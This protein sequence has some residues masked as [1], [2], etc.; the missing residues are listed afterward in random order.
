[1]AEPAKKAF[2]CG[3][4]IAH[5]R[6]PKIH[7]YWLK[8]HRIAGTYV[9]RD[10][11]QDDFARFFN[12]FAGDGFVGGNVTIPN[13]E[14]AFA[15][16]ARREE[17]AEA[18]GALNT[19]WLENGQVVGDNTDVSGFLANLDEWAPGWES[20]RAAVVVGAGGASRGIVYGLQ[21]RGIKD[22]RVANRTIDRAKEVA[23]HFGAGVTAHGT[24]ALRELC[25]DAGLL[26]N[27]TS[28]GMDGAG[29][30][31]ADPDWLP[32]SAIVNDAVY[33]PLV[34]PLLRAA[35]ARG[36]KTVDGL[37][38][39]LHQA[40]PG[41]EKWFGVRPQV[42]PELRALIVADLEAAH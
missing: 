14:Q 3:H 41:F 42:T 30:L 24:D 16:C 29:E 4:P 21:Q 5:S 35:K 33:V 32:D 31:P 20:A 7:G 25:V 11:A 22:V 17:T 26:V 8:Q 27:T 37:G 19:L 10:V 13:K 6:S 18:V 2:V 34:T 40:A 15:L 36:L 1:M 28:L 39:L 12:S 23:G 9:A 38:M